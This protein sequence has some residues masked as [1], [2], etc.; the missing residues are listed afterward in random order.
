M[1]AESSVHYLGC[2]PTTGKKY[3]ATFLLTFMHKYLSYARQDS[4]SF[5]SIQYSS[6][7]FGHLSLWRF[8]VKSRQSRFNIQQL[9]P[10]ERVQLIVDEQFKKQSQSYFNLLSQKKV[11]SANKIHCHYKKFRWKV[12]GS[13]ISPRSFPLTSEFLVKGWMFLRRGFPYHIHSSMSYI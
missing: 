4:A 7:L 3:R 1:R 13:L 9:K 2:P 6:I 8:L 10:L 5:F 12:A 11:F